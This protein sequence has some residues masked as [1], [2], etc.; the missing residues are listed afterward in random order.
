M[1]IEP[2]DEEAEV[3]IDA[4][5]LNLDYWVFESDTCDYSREI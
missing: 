2:N 4:T 1:I 3:F 5:C